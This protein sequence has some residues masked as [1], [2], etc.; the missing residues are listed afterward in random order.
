MSKRKK[1]ILVVII[2]MLLMIAA[3]CGWIVNR[4]VE[5]INEQRGTEIADTITDNLGSNAED[6]LGIDADMLKSMEAASHV[7]SH[8]GSA[9]NNE[10]SFSAYDAAIDA[11]SH[12][13]EQDVVIS[14]DGV[15]FVSHDLSASRLTGNRSNYSSM[16]ASEI[17]KLRTHAGSK[18]LRLSE[19]FEKYGTNINYVIE[20]KSSGQSTIEAFERSVEKYGVTENVIVQSEEVSVLEQIEKDYP[21]ML[22][23]HVC[24]TQGEFDRDLDLPYVDIISVRAASGLMGENNCNAAHSHDKLFS[25]WTLDSEQMIRRA[26]DLGVDTYF[27]NDTSLA[28]SLEKQYRTAKKTEEDK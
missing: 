14:S 18:V 3:A 6:L 28:L 1:T 10:H 20:L 8:R 23:L 25:A 13:I 17:D 19:V 22:K 11:G 5:S 15:L 9:G 21:D 27:T 2:L 16:S 7:Y 24:R 26:I 12:Y 4:G